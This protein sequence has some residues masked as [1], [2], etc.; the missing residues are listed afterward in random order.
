[1][2]GLKAGRVL[3]VV[4]RGTQLLCLEILTHA[5]AH[6]PNSWLLATKWL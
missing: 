2:D 4:Q 3:D 5:L 6:T 1:M